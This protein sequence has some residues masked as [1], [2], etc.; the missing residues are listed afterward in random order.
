MEH[1]SL[2]VTEGVFRF[3]CYQGSHALL[4]RLRQSSVN[5]SVK[6]PPHTHCTLQ[7]EIWAF[8]CIYSQNG[9]NTINF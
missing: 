2:S 6:S 7:D 1:S 9:E 4:I 5:L 3:K 8:V